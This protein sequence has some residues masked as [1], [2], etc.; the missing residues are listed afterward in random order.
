MVTKRE[1]KRI[2]KENPESRIW[3]RKWKDEKRRNDL[4]KAIMEAEKRWEVHPYLE[5]YKKQLGEKSLER[6]WNLETVDPTKKLRD[7]AKDVN[8]WMSNLPFE[9]LEKM[10]ND[11][12]LKKCL[13]FINGITD[14]I[15]LGWAHLENDIFNENR[16]NIFINKRKSIENFI[17]ENPL[18]LE[19]IPRFID[20]LNNYFRLIE[21]AF[22]CSTEEEVKRFFKSSEYLKNGRLLLK[23]KSFLAYND[24]LQP[25]TELVFAQKDKPEAVK[26]YFAEYVAKCWLFPYYWANEKIFEGTPYNHDIMNNSRIRIPLRRETYDF[27]SKEWRDGVDRQDLTRFLELFGLWYYTKFEDGDVLIRLAFDD[28]IPQSHFENIT[29]QARDKQE[30]M[31]DARWWKLWL[32][33]SPEKLHE[34]EQAD[35]VIIYRDNPTYSDMKNNLEK[36]VKTKYWWKVYCISFDKNIQ[37]LEDDEIAMLKDIISTCQCITDNTISNW[38]WL[39][40]KKLDNVLSEEKEHFID[41][42]KCIEKC[43]MEKWIDTVYLISDGKLRDDYF[44]SLLEHGWLCQKEDGTIYYVNC[45]GGSDFWTIKKYEEDSKRFWKNMFPNVNVKFV[46]GKMYRDGFKQKGEF[47]YS[48]S[49]WALAIADRHFDACLESFREDWWETIL[50]A[51]CNFE[52]DRWIQKFSDL[53]NWEKKTHWERIAESIFLW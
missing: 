23:S 21:K 14:L 37:S 52:P 4:Y 13:L 38:T 24:L 41:T 43:C 3:Q 53:N 25:L 2:K 16:R 51:W 22:D 31:R 7:L 18:L 9:E 45:S 48:K 5:K 42:A 15:S 30:R 36:M 10:V 12:N 34:L 26:K 29:I 49:K 6:E 17:E 44:I 19:R 39:E 20:M 40:T 32:G 50:F 1:F 27:D 28:R 35:L 33:I 46:S 11:K 47:S 8:E